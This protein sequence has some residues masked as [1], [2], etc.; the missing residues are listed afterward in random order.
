MIAL[1]KF[2]PF[3]LFLTMPVIMSGYDKVA[4][5]ITLCSVDATTR[6]VVSLP[7]ASIQHDVLSVSF[8]ASGMYTL[9]VEDSLGGTVYT[10]ALPANGMEYTYDL[11]GI[12]EGFFRLVIEGPAG[13]YE[14]YFK[15]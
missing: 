8:D 5:K 1:K 10:S 15:I 14:G 11:S 12:G 9:Y 7:E 3:L 13:E 4:R 2:L 6:S